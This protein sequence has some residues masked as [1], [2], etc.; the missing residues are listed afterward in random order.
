MKSQDKSACVYLV[1]A[2]PGSPGLLTVRGAELL[3]RADIVVY[4]QLVPKRML[5]C[6]RPDAERVCV[7]DLPGKHPEKYPHI[8]D[9]MIERA[10]AGQTV[11]RLKGGDPLIFGRG[12][13]EAEALTQAGIEYEIVPGVTAAL[14]AASYLDF[15]LTH[16]QFSSAVALVTGHELPNKAGNIL[17]WSALARFPGTLAI[18]M[19]VARL[20]I[21]VSELLKFG[22]DPETPS[23]IV[24]RAGTG[25]MRS[26]V[27]KLGDLV[28]ARRNAGLESPGLII[29]GEVVAL[30]R[31]PSWF[32]SKPL[33]GRRVLV[34]RPRHQSESF[35]R[36]LETL[37]AVVTLMPAMEIREP[38]DPGPLDQAIDTLKSGNWDWVVF[39]SANGV[40]ALVKR[41]R[42]KGRDLRVLGSVKLATVGEKTAAALR[43]YHLEPDA[44][45]AAPHFSA[46]ALADRLI[47]DAAGKRILLVGTVGG[48][49]TLAERLSEVADVHSVAA[50]EQVESVDPQHEAFAAMRRGEIQSITVMSANAARAVSIGF[51]D[52]I[53]GRIE[54]GEI[55][56]VAISEDAVRGF[57]AN[58]ALPASIADQATEDGMIQELVKL[59]TL[60]PASH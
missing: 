30:R 12:G 57:Q 20:P 14:A 42:A 21:I 38:H 59:V 18:Y 1:G 58:P 34:T 15:P 36:K 3:S 32:E 25:E 7:R 13:E 60:N 33:F 19:G 22:K 5:D 46:S 41:I 29:I 40:D 50:Y 17:D 47:H 24:E 31:E 48:K 11:V 4:D 52:V 43:Q 26:V 55:Q 49:K 8:F 45:P 6:V 53:R 56:I 16:R 35:I 51:D 44:V 27:A 39:S 37:G 2:G 10:R 9:L 28:E 23:C 54:R